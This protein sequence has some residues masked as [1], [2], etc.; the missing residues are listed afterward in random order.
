MKKLF[1]LACVALSLSAC[2]LFMGKPTSTVATATRDCKEL[3]YTPG[4]PEYDRCLVNMKEAA[5][6]EK[7]AKAKPK[8]RTTTTTTSTTKTI[9]KH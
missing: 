9:V 6:A 8:K 5:A 7:K 2:D 4:T 3:G 1:L